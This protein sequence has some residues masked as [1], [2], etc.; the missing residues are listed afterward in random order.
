MAVASA[1]GHE[2]LERMRA[3]RRVASILLACIAAVLSTVLPATALQ[4]AGI[5]PG[6]ITHVI[7]I[8]QENRTPDNLFHGLPGADIANFGLDSHGRI[9]PLVPVRIVAPFDIDH[10]HAAFETAYNHG[11]MN[12]F[13][14]EKMI[15]GGRPCNPTPYAYV[16]PDE[17][18]PYFEMAEQY[19]FGDRMFQTNQGPSFPAHLFL[20]SGTSAPDERSP[21]L[22]AE[23]PSYFNGNQLNCDG[24]TL[25]RVQLIDTSGNE[26]LLTWPCVDHL[27]LFDLLDGK[28]ISWRYY[29]SFVGQFW[30]AP[31]M[32]A[33]I[34][35]GP[36]WNN[37]ILPET[38]ILEDIAEGQLPGVS[39]VTPSALTSDHAL[40]T[41]GSG[42]EWVESIVNAVGNG[43]YWRNTAIFVV[44]DDWGGWYDH[45]P[46]VLYNSYELGFRVPLIVVS[47]Y[48][49]PHYVSHVQHEFG[50]ILRFTEETFGLGSLN[51]T[52]ARSD[53]LADCF[54]FSQAPLPFQTIVSVHRRPILLRT[55]SNRPPDDDF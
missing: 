9:K 42:P 45:V 35:R 47:P 19:T 51:H 17:V 25:S 12:G 55:N 39:W 53:D 44:W 5:T 7:I 41:D 3:L 21:L 2:E 18:R 20:V 38:T 8:I 50:S 48:A 22:V 27:T 31:D 32:I 54:N 24:S 49:R 52:D 16:P 46:P 30:S 33:H 6:V 28:G 14:R 29:D 23:N 34:R 10:T 36:D 15:C 43:P 4:R 40:A 1:L 37:V 13:D 11:R 26:N